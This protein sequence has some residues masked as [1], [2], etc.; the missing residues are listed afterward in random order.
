MGI[1]QS[2]SAAEESGGRG[3]TRDEGSGAEVPDGNGD[4]EGGEPVFRCEEDEHP[5]EDKSFWGI[6]N[7]NGDIKSTIIAHR[8]SRGEKGGEGWEDGGG[9]RVLEE[10][11]DMWW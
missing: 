6:D 2:K 7:D 11:V 9:V 1:R 10:E 4:R 8:R 5:P 3:V